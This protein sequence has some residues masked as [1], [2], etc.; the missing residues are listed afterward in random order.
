LQRPGGKSLQLHVN[1][2]IQNFASCNLVSKSSDE[3][4]HPRV[5]QYIS[6]MVKVICA[7]PIY[8]N[9]FKGISHTSSCTIYLTGFT[10]E[11]K[12]TVAS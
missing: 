1:A 4:S 9:I 11:T 6:E 8:K 10:S 2:L 3:L 7:H 12:L 5:L